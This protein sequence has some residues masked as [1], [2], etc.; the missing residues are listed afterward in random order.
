MIVDIHTHISDEK[1]CSKEWIEPILANRVRSGTEEA[2]TKKLMPITTEQWVNELKEAGIDKAVVLANDVTRIFKT[3]IPDDYIA[4]F[5]HDYE[6]MLVGFSSVEPFDEADRFKKQVL[7]DVERAVTE[8]GFKG[9]KLLPAYGNYYAND[10]RMYPLYEKCLELKIPILF[11]ISAV[12]MANTFLK[13]GDPAL[14]DNV[15]AD[16]P[17]LPLGIAH[18]GRPWAELCCTL[19]QKHKNMFVDISATFYRPTS[20]AW[21]LLLAKEYGVLGRVMFGTDGPGMFRP[22]KR[23]VDWC[24]TSLNEICEKAGWPRFTQDE[25][26]GILGNNAI[27]LLKI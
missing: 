22:P 12:S 26:N 15:A 24:K 18:F 3:K 11:H 8:F 7:D 17:E 27:R 21:N 13:Y 19:L 20:L 25:I 14:L 23:Y 1:Y 16:F 2:W 10:K 9:L 5:V 4:A 6:D